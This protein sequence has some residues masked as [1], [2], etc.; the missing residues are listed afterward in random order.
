MYLVLEECLAI[1]FMINK[2]EKYPVNFVKTIG[3][4]TKKQTKLFSE[5]GKVLKSGS[6]TFQLCDTEKP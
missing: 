1:K 6:E 4:N 3:T 5:M 2:G